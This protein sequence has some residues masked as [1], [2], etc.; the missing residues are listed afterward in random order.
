MNAKQARRLARLFDEAT[1]PLPAYWEKGEP[2]PSVDI[3][4][5]SADEDLEVRFTAIDAS[6][7]RFVPDLYI[8]EDGELCEWDADQDALIPVLLSWVREPPPRHTSVM[9]AKQ[10]DPVAAAER[11]RVGVK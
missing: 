1:P 6:L 4:A 11:V 7:V 10:W 5:R 9:V 8:R 2:V 3:S